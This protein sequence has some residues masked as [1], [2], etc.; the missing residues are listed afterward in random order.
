MKAGPLG[1][2]AS[3]LVCVVAFAQ[4]LL[5]LTDWQ[6]YLSY[7]DDP[8]SYQAEVNVPLVAVFAVA[9]VAAAVTFISWLRQVRANAEMFCRAPH[10]HGRGW[11]IGGWFVPVISLWYPKQIVDDVV[12]AS[13]PRTSPHA[14]RLPEE[15]SGIVLIWWATWIGSN[16]LD[17]AA[18]STP[19]NP[20]AGDLLRMASFSIGSAVLSVVAAVYA[21]RVVRLVNNLQ[22]SRPWTAWWETEDTRFSG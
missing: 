9:L 3:I 1:T 8:R 2:A 5:A 19:D 15:T 22:M 6:N 14:D 12:A 18:P 7:Q 17:L 13:S 16:L 21:V 10:R 11:V 4:L 20:A